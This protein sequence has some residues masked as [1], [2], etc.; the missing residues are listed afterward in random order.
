MQLVTRSLNSS[1]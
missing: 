1:Y